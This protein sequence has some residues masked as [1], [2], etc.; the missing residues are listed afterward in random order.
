LNTANS[1]DELGLTDLATRL[2]HERLL[3]VPATELALRH[4]GRAVPNAVLLGGFAAMTGMVSLGSVVHAIGERFTPPVAERNAA[5][6]AEAFE[7]VAA[8]TRERT[9]AAPD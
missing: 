9:D 3:T 8:E 1:P 5:A 2:R 7:Y 6:A 4:V